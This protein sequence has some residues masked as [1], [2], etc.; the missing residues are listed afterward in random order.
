MLPFFV[1]VLFTFYIQ[2]VLKFKRKFRRQRVKQP[3]G[4]SEVPGS[5]ET[6]V[7]IQQATRRH[8]LV[9]FKNIDIQLRQDIKCYR[10]AIFLYVGRF[11]PIIGHKGP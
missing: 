7:P 11:R 9:D 4:K 6:L 1:P 8:V 5:S 10:N 3:A 2:D